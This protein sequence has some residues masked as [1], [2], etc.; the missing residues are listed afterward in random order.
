MRL[1]VII[2]CAGTAEFIEETLESVRCQ[3][4]AAEAIYVVDN[5]CAHAGYQKAAE[6]FAAFGVQ[7]RRFD[8][9]LTMTRNWQRCLGVGDG[10]VGLLLNDDDVLRPDAFETGMALLATQPKA[11]GA[12]LPRVH[13]KNSPASLAAEALEPDTERLRKIDELREPL[14]GFAL[15]ILNVHHMSAL[16]F[17]RGTI[18]FYPQLRW[19]PDQAF[20]F[21]HAAQGQVALARSS[22]AMIRLHGNSL[23]SASFAGN[24]RA[25][26][27]ERDLLRMIIAFFVEE[28]GL[29][30]DDLHEMAAMIESG[31]FK[32]LLQASF[33]FPW[34]RSRLDFGRRLAADAR[35]R[36]FLRRDFGVMAACPRLAGF[37]L[38]MASEMRA[39]IHEKPLSG[40]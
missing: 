37:L 15:S 4:R 8:E 40:S 10:D 19:A 3:T 2:P 22:A 5:A 32:R 24:G 20:L 33:S 28:K 34:R 39:L 27:E 23:T 29:R 1:D 13:F 11:T 21:A 25:V 30:G 16:F 18:G 7:Y 36:K 26:L 17:R 31:G 12:L 14:R 6:R 38:G 35:V 9:R